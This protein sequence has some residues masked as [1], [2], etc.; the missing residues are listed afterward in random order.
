MTADFAHLLLNATR[1]HRSTQRAA[2]IAVALGVAGVAIIV[3]P[4]LDHVDVGQ[5]VAL[6]A[7]MG[8]AGSISSSNP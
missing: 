8:F 5:V 6:L 3:R 7:A 2:R 4:G 1:S